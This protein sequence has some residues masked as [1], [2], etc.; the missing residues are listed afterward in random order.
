MTMTEEQIEKLLVEIRNISHG[1]QS[2]AMGLEAVTM[3]LGG[4]GT[5]GDNNVAEGLNDI[6]ESIRD[7]AAAIR[8]SREVP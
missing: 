7:L 1:G 8:E 3:A 5:P 4:Q 6:A 2:G